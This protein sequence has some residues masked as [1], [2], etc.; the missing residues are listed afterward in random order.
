MRVCSERSLSGSIHDGKGGFHIHCRR[1]CLV[2]HYCT[3]GSDLFVSYPLHSAI[4]AP[5][6]YFHAECLR[7]DD[8]ELP[9]LAVDLYITHLRLPVAD[10]RADVAVVV[11]STDTG[12]S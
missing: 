2:H 6:Q 5:K 9:L 4:S 8:T 1:E 12:L 3:V 7:V 11:R 10:R